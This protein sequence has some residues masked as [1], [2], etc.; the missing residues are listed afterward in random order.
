[1]NIHSL[2]LSK[3]R[4]IGDFLDQTFSVIYLKILILV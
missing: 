4:S 1:L 3:N 2:I